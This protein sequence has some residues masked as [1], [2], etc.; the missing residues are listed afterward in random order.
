VQVWLASSLQR[1]A[2]RQFNAELSV[3]VML[4]ML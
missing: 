1:K 4:Q 3:L 2:Q